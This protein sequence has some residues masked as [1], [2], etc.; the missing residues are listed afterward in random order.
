MERSNDP[1]YYFYANLRRYSYVSREISCRT[2]NAGTE[3]RA[4]GPRRHQD[5]ELYGSVWR[6]VAVNTAVGNFGRAD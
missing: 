2:K 3:R 6:H 5:N 4:P 1:R